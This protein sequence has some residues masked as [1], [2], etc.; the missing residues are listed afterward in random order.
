MLLASGE[1][2]SFGRQQASHITPDPPSARTAGLLVAIYI[3]KELHEKLQAQ[4]APEH[5]TIFHLIEKEKEVDRDV[6]PFRLMMDMLLQ[7]SLLTNSKLRAH[8]F[9]PCRSIHL[10]SLHLQSAVMQHLVYSYRP[11]SHLTLQVSRFSRGLRWVV[12]LSTILTMQ[13][14]HFTEADW[15]T[16]AILCQCVH[17]IILIWI[18]QL[19]IQCSI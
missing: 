15:L 9:G 13:Q 3:A 7:I 14:T 4:E 11:I 12:C 18:A 2:A 10:L 16:N 1:W 5:P 6:V 8:T 17:K 19:E